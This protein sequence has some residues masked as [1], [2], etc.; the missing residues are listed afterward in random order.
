M[1]TAYGKRTV[2][3]V[4]LVAE[5]VQ[6]Q[7]IPTTAE[8]EQLANWYGWGGVAK[9]FEKDADEQWKAIGVDLM[10]NLGQLCGTRGVDEG[11][12]LAIRR[13]AKD[14]PRVLRI[15]GYHW[16][17]DHTGDVVRVRLVS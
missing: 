13:L 5:L 9:A 16:K 3:L 2:A 8:H 7:R 4:R 11:S 1:S 12:R 6:S 14:P 15:S 17:R 10:L